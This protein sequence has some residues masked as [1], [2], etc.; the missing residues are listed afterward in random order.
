M[1]K[2]NE[3]EPFVSKVIAMRTLHDM[4]ASQ[5]IRSNHTAYEMP[6]QL[7][8]HHP[9][10]PNQLRSMENDAHSAMPFSPLGRRANSGASARINADSTG[11]MRSGMDAPRPDV[12]APIAGSPSLRMNPSGGNTAGTRAISAPDSTEPMTAAQMTCAQFQR[13]TAFQMEMHIPRMM[14]NQGIIDADVFSAIR[15]EIVQNLCPLMGGF[16]HE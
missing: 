11:G 6:L 7:D 8:L 5:E 4:S 10:H 14:L 12:F 9:N 1:K 13:E 2:K 15:T 3:S 16:L